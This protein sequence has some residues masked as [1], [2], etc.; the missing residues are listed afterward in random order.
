MRWVT[1]LST[2]NVEHTINMEAIVQVVG[3]TD[4]IRQ[5]HLIGGETLLINTQEWSRQ[6]VHVPLGLKIESRKS[7]RPRRGMWSQSGRLLS[8]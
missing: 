5:V 6:F 2:D 7:S 1:L 8:S 4:G 3:Q